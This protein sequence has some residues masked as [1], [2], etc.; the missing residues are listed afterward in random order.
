VSAFS[1]WEKV[2][3]GRM[4]GGAY[5]FLQMFMAGAEVP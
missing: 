1:L 4:R 5:I 2:L 3:D